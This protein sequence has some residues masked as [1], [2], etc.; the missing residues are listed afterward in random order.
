MHKKGPDKFLGK[1][2]YEIHIKHLSKSSDKAKLYVEL[3][4]EYLLPEYNC[5][6]MDENYLLKYKNKEILTITSEDF[7]LFSISLAKRHWF[8]NENFVL[9]SNFLRFDRFVQKKVGLKTGW[10]VE[11]L[12]DQ[13]S[14]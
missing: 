12:P 1:W 3:S 10:G 4:D 5:H 11:K 2:Q 7:M 14:F 8:L 9:G 6:A 13:C